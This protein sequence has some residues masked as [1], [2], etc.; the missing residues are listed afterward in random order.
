MLFLYKKNQQGD[1]TAEQRR[2][3]AQVVRQEI[4]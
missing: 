1:L 2:L 4:E 3:F